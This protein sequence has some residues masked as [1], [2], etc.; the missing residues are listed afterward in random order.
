MFD[1]TSRYAGLP[2]LILTRAGADPIP[3]VARRFV[4]PPERLQTLSEEIV[5]SDD[6][7]DLIAFR[8]L[9]DPLQFWRVADAN[10]VMDPGELADEPGGRVRIPVPQP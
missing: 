5:Q 4:P 1:Q 6:R 2:V 3:Y 9:G 10:A 8:S 7:P